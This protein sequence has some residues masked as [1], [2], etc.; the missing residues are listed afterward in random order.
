MTLYRQLLLFTLVTLAC[1]SAGLWIGD[2]KRARDF[3]T[4][5]LESHAQDT[6]TSLGLSLSTLT[7]GTDIPAMEAM[8]NALFDRGFYR[9]IQLRDIEGKVVIDRQ[10]DLVIEGVPAWFIRLAQLDAPQAEAL[11][12]NGWQQTGSVMVASHPGYAYKALWQSAQAAARWCAAVAVAVAVLGGLG[13]RQLLRPLHKVEEQAQALCD[14]SFLIQ[15]R[16]PYTRELRRVVLAMNRMTERIRALFDEQTAIAETLRQRVY[17]D[18]LTG[19][20]NRRFLATQIKSKLEGKAT[21]G[22]GVLLLFQI[23]DL[24]AVNQEQGYVAG[25]QLIKETAACMQRACEQLPEAIAARL[26][27]G[28][29][30]LLL[31]NADMTMANQLANAILADL[32]LPDS[33]Q[34]GQPFPVACGGAIY[35]REVELGTLLATADAALAAARYRNDNHAVIAPS[36]SDPETFTIGKSEW[37]PLLED[38]LALGSV[39]LYSQPV[40][41]SSNRNLIM[42]HELLTR[43]H[44]GQGNHLSI[45]QLLPLA[46]QLGL[47]PAL[48]RLIL[49]RVFD[50]PPE[51]F[52]PQRVTVNLSP[53]SLADSSFVAWLSL[54][55][56][57][58]AGAGLAIQIEF[59]EFRAVRFLP[60][61]RPFAQEIR[62][63]GHAL[64]IDHF[65]QAF[66]H[67]GY[68]KSL[69]PDYVK[70]DRAITNELQNVGDDSHFFVNALC[71]VAH[72]LD[73]KVVVEGIETEQQWRTATSLPID[74]VQGFLI[75]RPEPV[76][77]EAGK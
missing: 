67:F 3:L 32:C 44:D 16:L 28:D 68:L 70:I 24:H 42:H 73:I 19:L 58:C 13:L 69:L 59:P 27:G 18:P 26:G 14:R 74:A 53:L 1:L 49:E 35:D 10:A 36:A 55:L 45:G 51:Q 54:H 21:P 12:M 17:Q 6:A 56:R 64:G 47:M 20:G 34:S 62:A 76:R 71:T 33:N 63:M 41:S 15:E 48:D 40:V 11:V 60:L 65:G 4:D 75:R 50:L 29:L 39:T 9:C 7:K 31:P 43:M 22:K 37:R 2:H 72:S 66:S 52:V 57:R 8:I 38:I 61:I 25:D 46:E 30:A 77:Q 23:R 5:Q